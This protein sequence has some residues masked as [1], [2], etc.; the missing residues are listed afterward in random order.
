[1]RL[2]GAIPAAVAN[3]TR[4]VRLNLSR[5]ALSDAVSVEVIVSASL[6]FLDL[7]YSNLFGPIPDAFA[8]SNKSPSS[9]SKLTLNDDDDSS[10]DSKEAITGSYQLVFL[11]LAHNALDGP[12]PESLTM[13]TK[14]Q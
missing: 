1:M 12:I 3:S 9:T 11:S 13:L 7:S 6:M 4:F 5:N 14:L 10:S 2:T 8:G